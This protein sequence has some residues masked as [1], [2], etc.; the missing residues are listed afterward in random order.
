MKMD[1]D[2]IYL[3]FG[4]VDSIMVNKTENGISKPSSNSG[5]KNVFIL[6]SYL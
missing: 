2:I 1:K 6:N 5:R 4:V 3:L